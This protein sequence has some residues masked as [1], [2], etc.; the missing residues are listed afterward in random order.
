MYF[1]YDDLGRYSVFGYFVVYNWVG[2]LFIS[3]RKVIVVKCYC[4]GMCFCLYMV[5]YRVWL[6]F[7]FRFEFI[8]MML[9]L[10]VVDKL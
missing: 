7:V 1:M 9:D 6:G 3:F 10:V 8:C 2:C 4:K 5:I